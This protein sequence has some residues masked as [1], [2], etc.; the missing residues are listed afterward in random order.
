MAT[1]QPPNSLEAKIVVLVPKAWQNLPCFALYQAP[2]PPLFHRPSLHNRRL[3][4]TKRVTDRT[5]NHRPPTDLDTAGQ[6]RFRSISRL[7]YRARMR[8]LCYDI[9]DE[10]SWRR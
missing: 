9:T 10:K 2:S 1:P 4:V 5:S 6:E 8:M 7:Y 3:L